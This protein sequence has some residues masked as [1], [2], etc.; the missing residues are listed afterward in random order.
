MFRVSGM[1][2]RE[3]PAVENNGRDSTVACVGGG[4]GGCGMKKGWIRDWWGG[5]GKV[6]LCFT[7]RRK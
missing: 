4:G 2:E 6:R 7:T 5:L 3:H 1:G